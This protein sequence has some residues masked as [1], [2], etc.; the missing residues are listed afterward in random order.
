MGTS[1]V[2]VRIFVMCSINYSADIK[3]MVKFFP[4][5]PQLWPVD[6]T[7]GPWN[8]LSKGLWHQRLV[9]LMFCTSPWVD[10]HGV[11]SRNVGQSKKTHCSSYPSLLHL[12][13]HFVYSDRDTTRGWYATISAAN[14]N[15]TSFFCRYLVV[16]Y[17]ICNHFESTQ[18]SC[19]ADN[20]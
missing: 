19:H 2:C 10:S 15:L 18:I 11:R 6:V 3:A 14:Y 4:C 8:S 12:R 16:I 7:Y 9:Y 20:L 5:A 13:R 1:K 17:C